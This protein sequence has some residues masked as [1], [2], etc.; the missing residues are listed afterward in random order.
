MCLAAKSREG[1][2]LGVAR[3]ARLDTD[4]GDGAENESWV[5]RLFLDTQP[6]P[7]LPVL[8]PNW[9]LETKLRIDALLPSAKFS[10]LLDGS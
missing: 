4:K 5:R 3:G 10:Y 9:I 8:I 6:E 7:A 1:G 2:D